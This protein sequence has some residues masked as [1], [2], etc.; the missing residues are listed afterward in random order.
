MGSKVEISQELAMTR[1]A[2]IKMK[3]KNSFTENIDSIDDD[4]SLTVQPGDINLSIPSS[5]LQALDGELLHLKFT[6]I[7]NVMPLDPHNVQPIFM[8]CFAESN[9]NWYWKIGLTQPDSRVEG[10][11]TVLFTEYAKYIDTSD[12]LIIHVSMDVDLG[13]VPRK[14]VDRIGY[15]PQY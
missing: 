4:F 9:I 12:D 14:E 3:T 5:T 7:V 2:T 13:S 11:A 8:K 1:S 10:V 15:G 6:G